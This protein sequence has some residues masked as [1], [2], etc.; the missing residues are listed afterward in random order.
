VLNLCL[1]NLPCLKFKGGKHARMS[2]IGL[3]YIKFVSISG[4]YVDV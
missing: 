2:A 4:V 1:G 3:N